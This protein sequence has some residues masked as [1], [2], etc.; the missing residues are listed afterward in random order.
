MT[1]LLLPEQFK[2]ASC[3]ML[4]CYPLVRSCTVSAS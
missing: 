4:S 2:W 1:H 3:S